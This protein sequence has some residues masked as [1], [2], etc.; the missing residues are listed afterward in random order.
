MAKQKMYRQCELSQGTG[1]DVAYIEER[2]AGLGKS[3]ELNPGSG[4]FWTVSSVSDRALPE[5]ELKH[6]QDGHHRGWAS[7]VDA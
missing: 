3:V 7:L 1:R 5:S 4:D 2:A 6:L